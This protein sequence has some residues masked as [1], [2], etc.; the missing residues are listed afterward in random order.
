MSQESLPAFPLWG[1][2][3]HLCFEYHNY[4]K[5]TR[6]TKVQLIPNEKAYRGS[7]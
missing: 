2:N 3:N 4:R 6:K 1:N 7:Q 5:K